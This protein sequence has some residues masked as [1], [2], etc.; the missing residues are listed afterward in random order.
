MSETREYDG[1][2]WRENPDEYGPPVRRQGGF[3]AGRGYE[4]PEIAAVKFGLAEEI[5]QAVARLGAPTQAEVAARVRAAGVPLSQPDV[6]AILN[7]NV[8][9]FALERLMQVVAALGTTVTVSS[10]ASE[11]G[12]GRVLVRHVPSRA[13]GAEASA[14]FDAMGA[15]DFVRCNIE[16]TWGGTSRQTKKMMATNTGKSFRRGSVDDR[17]QSKNPKSG[18]WTKRDA[19]SG[20]FMDQK[21]GGEPF[22]GVAKEPDRRRK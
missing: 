11:D 16:T 8:K 13:D 17:T 21:K 3:L 10:Q 9:A 6:S 19:E 14:S 5:Q 22:K 2:N 18:N 15:G 7:G 1:P 4:N 12:I 20:R